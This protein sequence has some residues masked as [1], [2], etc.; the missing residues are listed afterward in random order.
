MSL[1]VERHGAGR[2]LLLLHGWGL[3]SGV[4]R[5]VLPQLAARFRVRTLD[6]PGYGASRAVP[7]RDFDA[8]VGLV[9]EALPA[10]AIVCG[11]SLG[12][13]LALALATRTTRRLR[14][15]VLVSA[16]PCFVQRPG[17][18]CAMAA[19]DFDAFAAGLAADADATLARFTRLAAL[20]GDRGREAIRVLAAVAKEAPADGAALRATLAWLRDND[21]RGDA[22]RLRIPTL[23]IHGE[24]DAVTPLA[25]GRWLA[26]RIPAARF[27]AVP[28]CAHVPFLTH[29]DAFVAAIAGADG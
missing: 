23:A 11:W 25:A 20:N 21:V 24:M 10:D 2:D 28:G 14:A 5:G 29:P 8:A 4:W 17:W 13:Q 18:D 27:V 3:G 16:T 6:L 1:H 12:A 9:E 22:A 26:D 15:L 7:A 19:E